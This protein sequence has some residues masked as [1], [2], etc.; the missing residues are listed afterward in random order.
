MESPILLAKKA[1]RL[2]CK[3][4]IQLV[5]GKSNKTFFLC[6]LSIPLVA[7][8]FCNS[9]AVFCLGFETSY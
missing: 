2:E 9:A 6:L 8:L 4:M 5:T 7:V 1:L 3:T